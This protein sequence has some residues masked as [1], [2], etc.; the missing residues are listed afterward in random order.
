MT[1]ISDLTSEDG[2][3]PLFR[4]VAART[5]DAVALVFG[6]RTLTYG[7]LDRWSD[8]QAALLR[9]RGVAAGSDAA[10]LAR[11]GFEMIAAALAVLKCGAAYVPLDPEY[12]RERLDFMIEDAQVGAV[13]VQSGLDDLFTATR[14]PVTTLVEI[15]GPAPATTGV[16]SEPPGL[17][18]PAYVIYTSGSTGAPKG[19]EVSHRNIAATLE[20]TRSGSGWAPGDTGLQ[21]YSFGFDSS[22]VQIFV[23]LT[24]GSRLVIAPEDARRDAAR[25][26]RLVREHR[27]THLDLVPALLAHM[28]EQPDAARDLA[29]LRFV[30]SGGDVLPG[31]LAKRF[32]ELLPDAVLENHYGSTETTNDNLVWRCVPGSAEHL[33]PIGYPVAGTTIHLLTPDGEPVAPGEIGEIH[34]GGLAVSL[35]YRGRP[36]LTAERFIHDP[37]TADPAARLYRTGDLGRRRDDGAIEFHGRVDRQISVGGHRVEPA[38]VEAHLAD[39][40]AVRAAAVTAPADDDGVRR[41]VAYLTRAADVRVDIASIREHLTSR[42]PA[43]MVPTRYVVL[44]ELPLAAHGKVDYEALPDPEAVRPELPNPYTPAER[45]DHRVL[46]EIWAECLGLGPVG[47]HDDFFALGGT[48][49]V[50]IKAVNRIRDAF[51]VRLPLSAVF[52]TPTI[53]TL[54]ASLRQPDTDDGDQVHD[55]LVADA[56]APLPLPT[57]ASHEAAD[58]LVH[59][60]HILLTGATDFIGVH[61]LQQLLQTPGTHVTCLVHA[62]DAARAQARLQTALHVNRLKLADNAALDLVA[63]DLRLPRFGLD[64]AGFADLAERVD[65]VFHNGASNN[66]ARPY[67]ALQAPNVGGTREVLRFAATARTKAVHFISTISVMPWKEQPQRAAWL[68]QAL[69]SPTGLTYGFARSKWVAEALVRRAHEQGVPS[70]VLRIGRVVGNTRTGV[71]PRD[72]LVCRLILGGIAI[73]ALPARR[74]PEPW[75]PVDQV[76]SDIARIAVDGSAFGRTFHLTDGALLDFEDIAQWVRSYGYDIDTQPVAAWSAMVADHADNVAYPVLGALSA[77]DEQAPTWGRTNPFDSSNAKA[78]L[79][80]RADDAPVADATLLHRFLDQCVLD[81]LIAPP[82]RRAAGDPVVSGT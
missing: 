58:R 47:I 50:A 70:T 20:V 71:W 56:A 16:R 53:A 63:G 66:L 75:L 21:Q 36:A 32:A 68:E 80:P 9:E 22:V 27:V 4:T 64:D 59:P 38:E 35:G 65:V 74:T 52:T 17:D 51:G 40:P 5:P 19:V 24:A 44:D 12:P 34:V 45:P 57:T 60:A 41:L 67:S 13:A 23:P 54:A 55:V 39:H 46:A 49:L 29:T 82:P 3:V 1:T 8:S 79:G 6:T 73:G 7:D 43:H 10:I 76:V 81:G 77:T 31:S 42:L 69:P 72:E 2:I 26:V 61:L 48:S 18:Q 62:D 28:V 33:V 11:P 14:I 25:L 37:F 15:T 78:A 30:V